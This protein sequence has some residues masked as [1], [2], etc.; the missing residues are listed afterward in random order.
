MISQL[1]ITDYRGDHLADYYVLE[2][3]YGIDGAS[4]H[5]VFIKYSENRLIVQVSHVD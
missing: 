1:T 3:N 4:V 2:D 5:G